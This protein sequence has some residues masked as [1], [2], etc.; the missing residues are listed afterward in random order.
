MA[1]VP[2]QQLDGGPLRVLLVE[3]E[4]FVRLDVADAFRQAGF[5]VIEAA[6]VD[7][8]ME[9]I[10]AGGQVDVV[11]TDVQTPGLMNG[12]ALA[13]RVRAKFPL[14]PVI[15]TSGRTNVEDEDAASRLG[16]FLPKP[17]Q[18]AWVANLISEMVGSLP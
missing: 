6:E 1:A 3:D 15:I 16:K 2:L 5:E 12:L 8:A 11:F 14:M 10:E 17:Y 7:A 18:S 13:E 9:F 4:T